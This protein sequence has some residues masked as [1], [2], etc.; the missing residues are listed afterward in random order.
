MKLFFAK[1]WGK[2][3]LTFI[4]GFI[5]IFF[6]PTITSLVNKPSVIKLDTIK[7]S[8]HQSAKID[9]GSNNN[10]QNQN[11]NNNIQINGKENRVNSPSVTKKVTVVNKIQS[12]NYTFNSSPLPE[13]NRSHEKILTYRTCLFLSKQ[14]DSFWKAQDMPK[15]VRL[16][17]D[18]YTDSGYEYLQMDS[19]LK[20]KGFLITYGKPEPGSPPANG[21]IV[22]KS[23]W[24]DNLYGLVVTV[25]YF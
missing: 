18:E 7:P 16:L 19:L 8:V 1:Y 2:I 6:W 15:R 23:K 14:I 17:K 4:L 20:S 22:T 24:L 13:G 3:A 21:I 5:T 11:G 12:L 9:S 10:Q 25:G